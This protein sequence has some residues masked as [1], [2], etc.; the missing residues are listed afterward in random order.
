MAKTTRPQLYYPML[1]Q[2]GNQQIIRQL[3]E[4]FRKPST[5][6]EAFNSPLKI[7][8]ESMIDVLDQ[9]AS[10]TATRKD[11]ALKRALTLTKRSSLDGMERYLLYHR[12]L[13]VNPSVSAVNNYLPALGS[14]YELPALTLAAQYLGK[15][16]NAYQ[17][18]IVV[19]TIIAKNRALQGG[20]TIKTWLNKAKDIFS[21]KTEDADAG[22]PIDEI[23]GLLGKW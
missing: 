8:D 5:A 2:A 12:A 20:E 13:G 15:K 16:G 17:A 6:S 3:V 14:T 19:K 23:K 18:T 1:A 10:A 22:C 9:I 21:A 11:Q 4:E 7:N